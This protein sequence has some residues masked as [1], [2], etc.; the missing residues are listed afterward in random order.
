MVAN[1]LGKHT[2]LMWDQLQPRIRSTGRREPQELTLTLLLEEHF[3][4]APLP[5]DEMTGPLPVCVR[6]ACVRACRPVC[7]HSQGRNPPPDYAVVYDRSLVS[8]SM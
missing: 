7:V 4:S 3:Q 6:V 2:P 1:R 5:A 8:P